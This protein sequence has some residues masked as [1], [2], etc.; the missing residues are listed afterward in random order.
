ME[1]EKSIVKSSEVKLPAFVEQAYESIEGMKLFANMLLESKLVPDHFF[2]KGPDNKPDYTKG[3]TSAVVV[4]L[5]QAQQLEISPLTAL[6]DIVPVNGLLSIKGDLAKT[7]IFASGKL[8]KDSWKE[9]V[10]GTIENEN[11]KISITATRADNGITLTRSFSVDDAKRAGLW[12]DKSKL[13]GPEGWKLKLSS[14]YKYPSR[15]IAYRALGFLARDN[16]SDVLKNMYITEEAVDM[17]KDQTQIINT[18]EGNQITI[19]D[20]NFSQE[21]SGTLTEKAN[22]KIKGQKFDPVKDEKS[23]IQ[24]AEVIPD[25][26]KELAETDQPPQKGSVE[27]FQGDMRTVDVPGTQEQE[28]E[29]EPELQQGQFTLKEMEEMD[30]KVLLEIINKDSDMIEAMETIPGKNTNKKLRA[31]IYAYQIGKLEEHVAPHRTQENEQGKEDLERELAGA[32]QA[33]GGEQQQGNKYGL[34]IPEFDKNQQREFGTTKNLFNALA[35][36]G[37]D[38]NRWIEVASKQGIYPNK[39]PSKEEFCKYA[40]P[41]EIN[42]FLNS[43]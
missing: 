42:L 43:N 33:Q 11:M 17:P 20:Q 39:F 32:D 35:G 41:D 26:K 40:S 21:R 22:K 19:P 31:I 1:S 37:I 29:N 12:P 7:M 9:V 16:F 10:E 3:K 25:E 18:P 4:V 6:Q 13:S 27:S 24:D 28:K 30:T 36:I 8:K 34:E 2:E 14:W 23:N 38:N 15:M 5:L